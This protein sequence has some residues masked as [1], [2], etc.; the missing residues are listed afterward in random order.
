M[1]GSFVV[2]IL[3][4]VTLVMTAALGVTSVLRQGRAATRHALLT[5]AFAVALVLPVASAIA[6]F[7]T[8]RVPVPA[9]AVITNAVVSFDAVPSNLAEAAPALASPEP[10]AQRVSGVPVATVL[11]TIWLLGFVACFVPVAIGLRKMQSLG[12]RGLPW[13]YGSTLTD[14][15]AGSPVFGGRSASRCTNQCPAP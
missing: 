2:S 14:Y 10:A 11:E 13:Q 12:G 15:L 8:I 9:P 6:P 7:I 5:A 4:G 1:S 3:A